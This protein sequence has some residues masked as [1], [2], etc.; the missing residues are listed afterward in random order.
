MA[1]Q[2]RERD[3]FGLLRFF[4]VLAS[5]SPLFALWAIRGTC[6]APS[7]PC[8]VASVQGQTLKETCLIPYS[9]FLVGC[10]V[11]I[12]IPN[13]LIVWR[14]AAARKECDTREIIVGKAEDHRDHL[15]VYLFAMLLPFYATN[16]ANWREFSATILAI[17]FIVFLFWNCSLHY[18]NVL[19]AVFGYRIFTISP[20]YDGNPLSNRGGMVLITRRA[21]IFQNDRIV[22]YRLSNSVYWEIS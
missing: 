5:I 12:V 1:K 17:C 19:F 10:A 2:T 13:L 14:M 11:L 20:L 16:L 21:N 6:S 3:G 4:M 7:G 8:P 15:L 9:Y 22:P 18:M